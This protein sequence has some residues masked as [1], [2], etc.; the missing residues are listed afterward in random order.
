MVEAD[1]RPARARESRM[2]QQRGAADGQGRGGLRIRRPR[3]AHFKHLRRGEISDLAPSESR[4]VKL[5]TFRLTHHHASLVG[6]QRRS[7]RHGLP[8]AGVDEFKSRGRSSPRPLRAV[9]PDFRSSATARAAVRTARQGTASRSG[10]SFPG[11]A[12]PEEVP[13][14]ACS[15]S[16]FNKNCRASSPTQ[17]PRGSR[18]A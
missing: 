10:C 4:P 14:S 11:V 17:P 2:S 5:A 16:S 8:A 15:A 3:H 13:A 1:Q 9:D 6:R 12:P 18:S 7:R